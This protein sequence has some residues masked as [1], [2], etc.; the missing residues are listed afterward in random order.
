[1]SQLIDLGKLRFYFAG[2][3]DN[4]ATYELNDVVKYGGNIYVYTYALASS[5]HVPTDTDYWALMIEGLKF[6][7]A[8]NG[9][10]EYRVGDGV[11]HGGKVYIA[12]KTGSNQVP[13]NTTYWSQF[14]DGIQYEGSWSSTNNYQKNDVVVYGGSVYIA[15]QDNS[16]RL[17]TETAY[18][19]PFVEGIDAT[20]VWNS[21]TSYVPNQLAAYGARIYLSITNN[22]NKVPS[23]NPTDWV[24]FIDGV[25]A[26]GT[27]N[28]ATQ[29]HVNDIVVYGSTV[30]IAKGDTL[31]NT[32]SDTN[33]WEVLT[34]GTTIRGE[35]EPATEYLS[36]DVVNW[37]GSTYITDTFHSSGTSFADDKDA[38]KWTKYNSGIRYRGAWATNQ[39]YIE[40][41]VVSDGENARIAIE[42][43]LSGGSLIDDENKWEI[44][45]KGATGLL[46]PQGGRSGFVL[47]TTGEEPSFEREV[48]NLYFGP[49]A[50][51]FA[52][53]DASLTDV[54]SVA[55]VESESFVQSVVVNTGDGAATSADF[56]A[57]TTGSTN[58]AGWADLG[59]TG[60][61]FET[62][63]FGITG[64]SE[65]Y[66]F[67]TASTPIE[68]SVSNK[69][70][71]S[72]VATLTTTTAH[73][74][75]AGKKVKIENVGAPFN[76][77]HVIVDTPT[78]TTFTFAV[79]ASDVSSAAVDPV[80][81][82]TMYIGTGNLVL[83]TGDTG[84]DNKIVLAAGGFTS[85]TEQVSITP[86]Q[87]VHVEIATQ[88]TSPTTG[89]LTVVG[90]VGVT[91]D[92]QIAGDMTVIGNVD[93]QG[94]TKLPVGAGATQFETDAGITD[95]IVI[96][97][98]NSS[99]FVQNAL[100][101]LGSGT[102][103]SADYIAYAGEGDNETGWI[104]LGITNATFN[105]PTYGVTGPHDGYIFM[106][107]PN[108]TTGSGNLVLATDNTGTQNKIVFAAGGLGTGN[109]QMIITPNQNIHVEIATPSTSATTGAF[110]VVGGV[111]FTGATSLD[112]LI[113]V[114][115]LTYLGEGAEDF[116]TDAGLTNAKLV[117]VVEG[118]PYAQLAIYNPTPTSSTDLIVYADNGDDSSGWIDMGITGSAFQQAEFG[119][120]GPNDGYIFFEAPENTTGKGNLV[121]ATGANGTEN[122]IV[123]A[124]GG[125][126]SGKDQM[127]ITPDEN[128]HIEIDTPSISP[129]TGALTVVGGVGISGDMNVQGDVNISGQISFAGGGTTVETE[130]LAVTDPM[131]FVANGNTAGDVLD[132]SFL[133]AAT[134]LETLTDLGP[135]TVSNKSVTNQVATLVTGNVNHGFL[136]GDSVLVE[137]IDRTISYS[138]AFPIIKSRANTSITTD[139]VSN[140][141]IVSRASNVA[142]IVTD[143]PHGYSSGESVVVAGADTGYNGTFTIIDVPNTT[144]F[145]YSN[146]G[147]DE[148][149][150]PSG[151]TT[152]V[153]RTVSNDFV[154]IVTSEPHGFTAGKDVII[155]G[156]ATAYDG[157]FEIY[158]T[159][160]STSFR[161][162]QT[163][164]LQGPS[165]A[166][167]TATEVTETPVVF[168]GTRT[169]T[170][171]PTS[172]SF[173]FA[174]PGA[175]DLALTNLNYTRTNSVTAWKIETG[176]LTLYVAVEPEE[177]AGDFV[178]ISGVNPLVND[179]LQVTGSTT[180]APYTI[181]FSIAEDDVAL[182]ELKQALTVNVTSRNRQ[183][184]VATL[185]LA[186]NHSYLVGEEIVVA[187]VSASFNGT[188]VV[189]DIPAPNKISY[190]QTAININETASTGTVTANRPSP[191]TVTGEDVMPGTA[192]VNDPQRFIG[193]YTGL[194]RNHN[195]QEWY[196]FSGVE[197]KPSA[198]ID[199]NSITLNN[200]N[201]ADLKTGGDVIISGTDIVS[202]TANF[203]LL[204]SNVTNLDFART[205]STITM[206][207][208][209]GTLNLQSSTITPT[210]TTV[211]LWNTVAT[212]ANVL[213]AATTINIGGSLTTLNFGNTVNAQTANLFTSSTGTSNYNFGTGATESSNT[214]TINIGTNGAS[215]STTNVNIGSQTAGANGTISLTAP[216]IVTSGD[217]AVG[218]DLAI[219][220]KRYAD[221]RPEIIT[222][223]TTLIQRGAV[224]TNG[225]SS[226]GNYFVVPASGMV[227]TLPGSPSLGDEVKITDIA[228]TSF[229]TPFTVARNGQRIQGL[230]EDLIFNINSHSVTLVYSNSTYGWRIVR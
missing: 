42:D 70:L 83:A 165:P 220:T 52:D 168:N 177:V 229:T 31:G 62:E 5:G 65:G 26:M 142:T 140:V 103:S 169:V 82:A 119:V 221:Q 81:T 195:N 204:D 16:N 111:G 125:F 15:K 124:A 49:G 71:T 102:S 230:Q 66:V 63:E 167:G 56:I 194:S 131:I 69:S 159:P 7:G 53:V 132:F 73:D 37:G 101:N 105:D 150:N 30:Y 133:G 121:L 162:I 104:D 187:G 179:T 184:N 199:F 77:V 85:G 116:E 163:G 141:T 186:S 13:P 6:T 191:G 197:N 108:G 160:T 139:Y 48:T 153:S 203:K 211:N 123:F 57:Y 32:P 151:G 144:S 192:F 2:L 94:V 134:R 35:W 136:V 217:P 193:S 68:A 11:A 107:A 198:T 206:G 146:T 182:T 76:G 87:N 127:S 109:E 137:D 129:T 147:S 226:T 173:S 222:S 172:K 59:F 181:T 113:R 175:S 86:G 46:P 158:D 41:D 29:Y 14:A 174:A 126:S 67:A 143:A 120:T 44:L 166:E 170:A 156:V 60:P 21:A 115:G 89:A 213:G 25:R 51:N 27:Y 152:T 64:P 3:Y 216:N 164:T 178:T 55:A 38:G 23:Q 202:T 106:S 190:A 39:F 227:L 188:Y 176:V 161:Y 201:V 138:T 47:T 205:A 100:V 215:G 36:G 72:G 118:D 228:G 148:S 79:T 154:T 34:S 40:G 54:A 145:T 75:V 92:M 84:S 208:N 95:A 24:T 78:T 9:T 200:L 180:T 80:G 110:T 117:A 61:N 19:D 155:Y 98:G 1:M 210:Q 90:G 209:A 99:S 28:S 130:N 97:A 93:L 22:T 224:R 189:S 8:W 96:A 219:A 225:V 58:D 20:G 74:F 33:Y 212:T 135:Y 12:I 18:W 128:V 88:S 112:G 10:T 171:V 122:K 218:I 91:G 43:H 4:A 45:A 114:K 50:K 183:N 185:T 196:L 149:V 214:K 223:S 157:T 207:A 17:P